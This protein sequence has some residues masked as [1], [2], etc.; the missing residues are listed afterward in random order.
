LAAVKMLDS[1]LEEKIGL[2]RSPS[3][4]VLESTLRAQGR[5]YEGNDV[6]SKSSP[7]AKTKEGPD[8][9]RA[10]GGGGPEER[11]GTEGYAR[12]LETPAAGGVSNG[13]MTIANADDVVNCLDLI[14]KYYAQA[15]PSSPVPILLQRARGL[16]RKSFFQV[17]DDLAPEAAAQL[18]SL[19]GIKNDLP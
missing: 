2:T 3:W 10:E 16:V 5:I 19:A 11:A 15:E 13:A 6:E 4:E 17:I 8:G 7:E 14:C 9:A 1:F 18:R 12:R